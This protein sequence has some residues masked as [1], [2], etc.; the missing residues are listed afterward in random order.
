MLADA[1]QE[2]LNRRFSERQHLTVLGRIYF[3]G[4]VVCECLVKDVSQD[5]MRLYLSK[6]Q[7]I[8]GKFEV[9]CDIFEKPVC[10]TRKWMNGQDVG[11]VF[12][13]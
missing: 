4:A 9:F 10:V 8:P 1:E 3:N 11:T 2:E 7:W 6:Q 5:G 13:R 12:D